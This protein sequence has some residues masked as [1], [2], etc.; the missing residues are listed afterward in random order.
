[1]PPINDPFI[2]PPKAL[3]ET[4]TPIDAMSRIGNSPLKSF[5]TSILT[6]SMTPENSA[7]FNPLIPVTDADSDRTK[8]RGLLLISAHSIPISFILMGSQLGHPTLAPVADSAP[9]KTPNPGLALKLP[10]PMKAKLRP[11]PVSLKEA[12]FNSA[13][14]DTKLTISSLSAAPVL[15]YRSLP[16]RA[17][18]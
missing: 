10:S 18:N 9:K 3:A 13:P 17:R 2:F 1:M 6:P 4:P 14:M 7:P 11:S 12:T 16:V 5:P 8:S 15:M